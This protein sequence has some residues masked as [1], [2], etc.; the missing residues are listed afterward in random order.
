MSRLFPRPAL[1]FVAGA[2]LVATALGGRAAYAALTDDVITACSKPS[3]GTLYLVGGSAPT[4]SPA[5]SPSAGTPRARG[6]G[7]RRRRQRRDVALAPGADANCPLGGSKFTS[8]SGVTY[9]CNGGFSAESTSPNG[10]YSISLEDAGIELDGPTGHVR[11]TA[12]G[13]VIESAGTI[14]IK[15]SKVEIN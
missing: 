2:L 12:S 3:N 4:V 6:R 5:T 14:T 13:I 9:A 10:A 1:A 7:R 8:A 15:G 11:L